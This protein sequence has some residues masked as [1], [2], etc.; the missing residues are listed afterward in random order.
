MSDFIFT[1]VTGC[2]VI[3]FTAYHFLNYSSGFRNWIAGRWGEARAPV[4]AVEFQRLS[5]LVILGVIPLIIALAATGKSLGYFGWNFDNMGKVLLW[6]AAATAIA[7]PLGFLNARSAANQAM[8]PQMRVREW[9]I[10]LLLW[11]NFTWVLYLLG[12]ET[13][14]R[15]ILFLP[16]LDHYGLVVATVLN[17]AIYSLAHIP[18]GIKET[19]GAIPFGII[20]C[21]GCHATGNIWFPFLIHCVM[22]LSNEWFSI[23][24]NPDMHVKKWW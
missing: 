18:K 19:L 14:F 2:A 24:L 10:G 11:S 3:A 5:G 22:A 7:L 15:G 21:L 6:T 8:Y 1:L 4:R 12:Y 23:Y 13:L 9:T 16:V 20:V 17:T